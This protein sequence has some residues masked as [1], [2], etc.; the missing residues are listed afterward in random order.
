[1]PTL[2]FIIQAAKPY[3]FYLLGMIVAMIGVALYANLQS[4][5]IKLLGTDGR[6]NNT[7]HCSPVIDLAVHG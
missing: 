7:C 5:L 6:E 3:K 4:Y 2:K 1:M